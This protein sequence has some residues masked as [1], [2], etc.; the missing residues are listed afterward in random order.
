MS[1]LESCYNP[2]NPQEQGFIA[3]IQSLIKP[4]NVTI[5]NQLVRDARHLRTTSEKGLSAFHK[6]NAF[7]GKFISSN[8]AKI[9]FSILVR[10]KLHKLK[11]NCRPVEGGKKRN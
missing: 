5:R 3:H 8:S 7:T 6:S 2:A 10:Q 1:T 4:L 11:G 9:L